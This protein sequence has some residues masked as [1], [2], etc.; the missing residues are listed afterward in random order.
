MIWKIWIPNKEKQ[1][2]IS[3]YPEVEHAIEKIRLIDKQME[4]LKEI[5]D[6]LADLSKILND[7]NN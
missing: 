7:N 2:K 5:G 4:S 3:L 6:K 1:K